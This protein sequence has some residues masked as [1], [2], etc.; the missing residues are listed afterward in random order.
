MAVTPP[1]NVEWLHR[2]FQAIGRAQ[3]RYFLLLVLA[4]A[5]TIGVQISD[6][7]VANVTFL[8]VSVY[9]G[10]VLAFSVPVLCVLLLALFGSMQAALIAFDELRAHVPGNALSMHQVDES[11]NIADLMGSATHVNGKPTWLTPFGTLVLYPIPILAMVGWTTWLWWQ[12]LGLPLCQPYPWVECAVPRTF[13]LYR[14]TSVLVLAVLA[15]F[16][17]FVRRRLQ[18][19]RTGK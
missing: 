10:D 12:G 7:T 1:I 2:R 4:S 19:F 3:T 14:V 6:A 8:G 5:Y 18:L 11:P 15:A 17:I 13:F 9:K 16:A